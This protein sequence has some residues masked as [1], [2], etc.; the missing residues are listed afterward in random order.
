MTDKGDIPS[1]QS[2]MS[3]GGPK[4]IT[5]TGGPHLI[6]IDFYVPAL[7][8]RVSGTETSLQFSEKTTLFAIFH[9]YTGAINKM[10]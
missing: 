3:F 9:I 8:P 6:F 7:T 2:K 5:Q 1:I 10:T 4:S